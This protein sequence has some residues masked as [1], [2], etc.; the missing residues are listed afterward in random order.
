MPELPK[1]KRARFV[2]QYQV[3]A[4]DAGVLANDLALAVFRGGGE[5]REEAED[6]REL[7]SERSAERAQ[8]RRKAIAECPIPPGALD[9]LVNLIEGG[10]ISGKQAK[11]VFAEMFASGK[12]APQS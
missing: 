9:E 12:C 5:R 10:K 2:Q 7:D 3:S 1:A 8:R 6:Y 11:E 4:Y